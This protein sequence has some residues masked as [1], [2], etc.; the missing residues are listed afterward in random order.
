MINMAFV[1]VAACV[2]TYNVR[3]TCTQPEPQINPM[4]PV[5]LARL[6]EPV[7]VNAKGNTAKK[8]ATSSQ[9]S[10][11]R[12]NGQVARTAVHCGKIPGFKDVHKEILQEGDAL[13]I[14]AN[15]GPTW[16][17]PSWQTLRHSKH[18][19]VFLEPIP[20]LYNK[21]VENLNQRQITNFVAVNAAIN[22]DITDTINVPTL[23]MYCLGHPTEEV[24]FKGKVLEWAG[25]VCTTVRSRL[26]HTSDILRH[27][28]AAD[29]ESLITTYEVPMLMF[30]QLLKTAQVSMETVS[31][32]QIDVEGIDDHV[33][34]A[35]PLHDPLFRP[36]GI[37]WED[38]L[39]NDTRT[40]HVNGFL[41][42]NDYSICKYYQN[43]FAI[44]TRKRSPMKEPNSKAVKVTANQYG[45]RSFENE[46]LIFSL[47]D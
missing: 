11:K 41:E 24:K 14:G 46:D 1:I 12:Y 40:S 25:Q 26:F 5:R 10:N 36:R 19:K 29:V 34:L 7:Q 22:V 43:I 13:I 32:V 27:A 42:E 45:Y 39:F 18:T 38:M 31:Y 47:T 15:I 28:S 17:D 9:K 35:L 2:I 16:T 6:M 37:M 21:L 8:V 20:P 3:P 33:V 4:M 23:T 30:E 44:D